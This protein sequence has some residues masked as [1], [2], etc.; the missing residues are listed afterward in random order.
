[1]NSILQCLLN[2]DIFSLELLKN[3]DKIKSFQ[4]QK[5]REQSQNV[6]EHQ[7]LLLESDQNYLYK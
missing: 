5:M 2:I 4:M 1:M 6:N 7:I 3:Y